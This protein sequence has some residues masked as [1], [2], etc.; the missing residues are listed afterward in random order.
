MTLVLNGSTGVSAVD[1]SASIPV[2]QGT[3]A[4]TGVFFPAADIVAISTGGTE[5]LRVTTTGDIRIQDDKRFCF[6]SSGNGNGWSGSTASNLLYAITNNVERMRIDSSGNVGIG[7]TTPASR[8]HVEAAVDGEIFRVQRGGGTNLTLLRVNMNETNN[9]GTIEVTAAAGNPALVFATA[10]SER[11]RITGAGDF[12]VGTTAIS[13]TAGV[14]ISK[15][16][17]AGGGVIQLMKTASGGTNGLLCYYGSTYVGG[18]N[19]DNTSTS[20]PTS[21]DLRLKTNIVDAE[22]AI[23]KLNAIHIVSHGWKND[24]ANV[25]FGVIAQ[26]LVNIAPQA[27]VRGDDGEEIETAWGVDYSKLVPML[28]KSVQELSAKVDSLQTEINSMKGAA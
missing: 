17:A 7:T 12:L 14:L 24:A 4:N 11:A 20:F 6:G 15:G 10:G 18:I 19:Y 25:E 3:D 5:R 2:V 26:E 8:L 28:I 13:N 27:V 9:T 16:G 21:S 1:G 22:K 23:D